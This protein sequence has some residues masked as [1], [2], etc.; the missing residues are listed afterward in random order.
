M[1]FLKDSKNSWLELDKEK[2]IV[3][4]FGGSFHNIT[5]QELESSEIVECNSWHELYKMKRWCPLEVNIRWSNV[6]ISPDGLYYDGEAHENRA[7]ELLEIMYGETDVDWAGDRLEEL[8]F[9]R[10][11]TSLMW[12]VRLDSDYWEDKKLSQKQFDALWD[13]CELHSKSFPKGVE[14]D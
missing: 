4:N 14:V 11:T 7:E 1:L 10:A 6:W 9:V 2:M 13:W 5:N 12:E 3:F 8:G